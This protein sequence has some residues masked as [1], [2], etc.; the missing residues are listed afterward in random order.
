MDADKNTRT[1]QITK[2]Q[3]DT[4][5]RLYWKGVVSGFVAGASFVLTVLSIL[6]YVL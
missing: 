3:L 6:K 1:Y 2:K 4:I 5:D